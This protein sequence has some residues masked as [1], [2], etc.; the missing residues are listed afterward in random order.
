[1]KKNYIL[2][3]TAIA[4][5]AFLSFQST[6]T[7]VVESFKKSHMFSSGGQSGLTGAP[8]EANCTQCHTGTTQDGTAEN[9]FIV[10]DGTTPVSNYTPGGTYT[11]SVQLASN[12]SKKGFSAT[13]LDGTDAMAGNLVG[14]GVGGTQNFS[15]AGRDYVS[16][17]ASSNTSA[18]ALWFWT[19][20]APATDVGTVTFYV[21]SNVTND[22]SAT[23]GDMIYLSQHLMGSTASISEEA[24]VEANFTAGYASNGNKLIVDFNS[25]T[26]GN[27]NLNLVD[28]NGRSVFSSDLGESQIGEN[29]ESVVLPS[30]LE[31]GIYIVNFFVGNKAM[32]SKIMIQK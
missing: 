25:L 6:N 22:D 10:L 2:G 23:S 13:V 3:I 9:T 18:S 15:A 24:A 29:N 11:V 5:I 4:S 14:S 16:H 12:P 32:S 21:A 26:V 27:M 19:W 7:G 17:T 28:M 8:G 1:M 30:E 31:G 20:I